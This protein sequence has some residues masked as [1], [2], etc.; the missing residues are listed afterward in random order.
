MR[1]SQA[2]HNEHND[3]DFEYNLV[4]N[5]EPII[6]KRGNDLTLIKAQVLGSCL[7]LVAMSDGNVQL[8]NFMTG[9]FIYRL[10]THTIYIYPE[11]TVVEAIR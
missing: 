10:N 1:V 2:T 5:W 9:E 4:A 3:T 11:Q 6:N 7:C 8:F